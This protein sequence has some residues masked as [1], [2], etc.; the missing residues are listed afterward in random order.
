[1]QEQAPYTVD[2]NMADEFNI[3]TILDV[4]RAKW[5]WFVLSMMFCL[6]IAYIYVKTVPVVYKR[7]AVVQLKSKA[8]TEEA[9]N[10]KQMFDDSN[11]ID[12]E[13]LIFKSRLLMRQVIDRLRLEI[14]YSADQGLKKRI[15]YTDSPLAVSFPDSTFIHSATF[16][17]FPLENDRFRIEGL[18]DDPD[19]VMEYTFGKPL[20]SPVGRMVVIRTSFFTD[21][22]RDT[23]IQVV[24]AEKEGLVSSLLGGLEAERSVKDANLITLTYQDV[25]PQRGDDILNALIQAYVDESMKDK[26]MIIRNTATFIDERLQ[27]I[28]Q[29]LGNVEGDIE[30]YRKRNQSVDLSAEAKIYLDN[31]NRYD[32]EVSDLTNQIELIGLIQQYLHDPLKEERLLP[33]NTGI[34]NVGIESMI[35]KYNNILLERNKLKVNAGD[36]S[37]AVKERSEE[38]VSLRH[39]ISESLRNTK[40]AIDSKLDFSRRMQM[41]ETGKISNIPTQQKYVLSVER[42]QKIKEELFLYLLNKREE[43]AL[44]LATADSNLR[45]VDDAYAAGGGG[46]NILVILFG[47]LIAGMVIPGMYFYISQLVDVKVRGRKDIEDNLT[48]PFLGEIPRK[49]AKSDMVVVREHGRDPISESFRIVRSNLDFMLEKK[50]KTQSIMFTS[51]NPDSGKTFVSSNLAVALALAGKRVLLLEMDIRKGSEKDDKGKVVPGLTNYLSGNI[52]DTGSIIRPSK[53]HPNLD[54]ITSGPIP[55]NPAELLLSSRLDELM[56]ELREQYEYILLDT[57]PYGIV[58]DAQV[59]SRVVDLCVYVI[60]EKRMDRRLLPEVEKLY[61]TGKLPHMAVI[62]NEACFQYTGYGYYG[63]YGYYGYYEYGNTKKK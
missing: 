23:P 50:S 56:T 19:G 25:D 7:E 22:W 11:N 36:N 48:I 13:I 9:F 63:N 58:A 45:V 42:Q 12:G 28:N 17:I 27:L 29:E 24:C 5:R 8:K 38:L 43:N 2:F 16:T 6:G 40:E 30:E 1:M 34:A 21:D 20:N 32:R 52:T 59:I 49:P 31:R 14:G 37:P 4:L 57:V 51:F 44:T 3:R 54:V 61:S 60:R 53:W 46:A 10:E 35:E 55:P 18:E 41:L 39:S 33:V 62:L 47:A 26:N 15:L